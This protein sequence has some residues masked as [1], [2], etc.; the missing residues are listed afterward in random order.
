MVKNAALFD[1]HLHLDAIHVRVYVCVCV[2]V[3]VYRSVE[4]GPIFLIWRL[5]QPSVLLTDP[6][7]IKVH[8]F[9]IVNETD[10]LFLMLGHSFDI[11]YKELSVARTPKPT[12]WHMQEVFGER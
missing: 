3:F 11:L 6:D 12:Y 10:I 8:S 2:C 4:V 9:V 5:H 7:A 1:C